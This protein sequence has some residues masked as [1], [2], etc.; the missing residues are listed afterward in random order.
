MRVEVI[1]AV[2]IELTED[3]IRLVADFLGRHSFNT[4]LGVL[5]DKEKAEAMQL[6]GS[7]L[8][9]HLIEAAGYGF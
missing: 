1:K 9:D 8:Y 5:Q 6:I 3:E 2:R 7:E 4:Y